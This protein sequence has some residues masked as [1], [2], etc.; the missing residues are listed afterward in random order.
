MAAAPAAAHPASQAAATRM[1]TGVV[2]D[3]TAGAVAGALIIARIATRAEQ[4]A[5]TGQD[6]RFSLQ[7]AAPADGV[8][9]VRAGGFAEKQQPILSGEMD[10]TLSPA[11]VFSLYVSSR[12][13]PESTPVDL[14]PNAVVRFRD[15]DGASRELSLKTAG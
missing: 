5:V 7:I 6:G 12:A 13:R 1:L 3:S 11:S 15:A 14:D 2:R 10:I 9:I 4:Q 8:L